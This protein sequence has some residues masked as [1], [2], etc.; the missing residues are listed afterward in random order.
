MPSV[1]L[2]IANLRSLVIAKTA[3]LPEDIAILLSELPYLE[4]LHVG[5]AY[6]CRATIEFLKRPESL[7]R[8]LETSSQ[9]IKH[10]SISVELLPCC[11]ANFRLR[12][13]DEASKPFCGMLKKFPNLK[14]A[15]LPLN[16]LVGWGE[17]IYDLQDVLPSTLEALHIRPD[18]WP[19]T[20]LMEFEMAALGALESFMRHKE[21]GSHP[22]LRTFSYEGLHAY[23]E[24]ELDALGI[25]VQ[26]NYSYLIKREAMHL[27]CLRRG[28]DLF[29]RYSDC[30]TGFML[31]HA[32][33]EDNVAYWFPWPFVGLDELPASMPREIRIRDRIDVNSSNGTSS[34]GN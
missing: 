14:T 24:E 20:E 28:Y 11:I 33:W 26:F 13:S 23:D 21:G 4:S 16:F 27:F 17:T 15:S 8:S 19:D 18:L 6:K 9:T 5:L 32:M 34:D 10:L 1:P 12:L 22:S 2:Q 29:S 30:T 25:Q 31:K 3:V 7:L